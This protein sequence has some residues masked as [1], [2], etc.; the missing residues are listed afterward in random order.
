MRKIIHISDIHFGTENETV[1]QSLIKNIYTECPDLIVISGDLTQRA[2][3]HQFMAAKKFL[4]TL[5]FPKVIVP[6]NHDITLWNPYRR[7]LLSNR[8]FKKYI[9]KDMYPYFI[10]NEIAVVGIN[11]ARAIAIT[12]GRISRHQIKWIIKQFEQVPE[13]VAKIVVFHHNVLPSRAEKKDALLG[14][15]SL[16]LRKVRHC[17]IDMILTGHL[18]DS[19]AS[20]IPS[21]MS[22]GKPL[23]V[24]QAGTAISCRLRNGLNEYNLINITVENIEITIKKF[25][26][27]EFRKSEAKLFHRHHTNQM[28]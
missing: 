7:I 26:D 5:E 17:R 16:F 9:N 18:H 28:I 8:R 10:D 15:L 25:K 12:G 1:A 27:G 21:E 6:G 19:F 11:T 24:S 23:I 4:D 3:K 14:G 20:L 13:N 2:K 22:A